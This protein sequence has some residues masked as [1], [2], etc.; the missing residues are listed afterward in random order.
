MWQAY[1]EAQQTTVVDR[2]AWGKLRSIAYATNE[3][4]ARQ[5]GDAEA[6][7]RA[8]IERMLGA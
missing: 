6:Y 4:I 3:E 7:R 5:R 8:W 2:Q 1:G